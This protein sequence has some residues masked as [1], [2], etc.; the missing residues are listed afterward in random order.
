M[1]TDGCEEIE[2]RPKIKKIVW[3]TRAFQEED[4][5]QQRKNTSRKKREIFTKIR[6][7]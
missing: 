6:R 5:G 3:N 1:N 7:K 4:Y 2:M